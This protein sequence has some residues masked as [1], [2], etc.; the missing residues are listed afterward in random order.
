MTED[1][2]LLLGW[3]LTTEPDVHEE[4][5]ASVPRPSLQISRAAHWIDLMTEL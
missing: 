4:R 1:F 2:D 3:G 5:S